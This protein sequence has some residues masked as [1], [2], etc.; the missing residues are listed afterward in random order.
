[1][2]RQQQEKGPPR[3]TGIRR[4][5]ALLTVASGLT[6]ALIAVSLWWQERPLTEAERALQQGNPQLALSSV[7]RFLLTHPQSNR[8]QLLKARTLVALGQWS[9]ATRVFERVGAENV[10]DWHAWATACLQQQQWTSATPLLERVLDSAPDHVD[11]LHEITACRQ[12]F[13]G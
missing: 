13:V 1:M 12:H 10:H 7:N 2:T 8:G 5:L 11:A 3:R 4:G 9:E 6:V